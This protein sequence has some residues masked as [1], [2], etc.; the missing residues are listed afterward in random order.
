MNKKLLKKIKD[1]LDATAFDLSGNVARYN[2]QLSEIP[3]GGDEAD[4]ARSFQERHTAQRFRARDLSMLNKANEA[5]HKMV[6]G[7]YGICEGCG[8]E[9][10]E[11]RLELRPTTRYCIQCQ[12]EKEQEEK[13]Y[14]P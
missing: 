10:D 8:E 4:E 11:K 3:T 2:S 12:E 14:A 13:K 1:K 5:L 6:E 7:T 9:I